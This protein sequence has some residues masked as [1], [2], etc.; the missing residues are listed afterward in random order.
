M[1]FPAGNLPVKPQGACEM[2]AIEKTGAHHV[3][4]RFI[5]PLLIL[6]IFTAPAAG[7]RREAPDGAAPPSP[8]IIKV[9]PDTKDGRAMV[10]VP[11]GRF[12]QG[13]YDGNPQELPVRKV[14]ISPFWIDRDEVSVAGWERFREATGHRA[15]KYS[16]DKTLHQPHLPVVG[17]SWFDAGAYCAWAVKRLPTEAEWEKAARGTDARRYPWGD[18]FDRARVGGGGPQPVGGKPGGESPYGARSM[19]GGVWEWTHDFWGEFYYREAPLKDPQGPPSG[20]LHTIRGGSWRE[21]PEYL[22]S[23]ERFRLDG[24][25]RWKILGFRCAKSGGNL[26]T[27]IRDPASC[28]FIICAKPVQ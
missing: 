18:F 8:P 10:F 17:V 12:T 28:G 11:G 6:L 5:F 16:R 23:A 21:D 1:A 20:F 24:I 2:R 25:I 4:A 15:S 7:E 19:A 3:A 14:F 9:L 27:V 22:R 26:E 13:S